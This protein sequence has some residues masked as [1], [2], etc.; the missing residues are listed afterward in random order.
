M[1]LIRKAS[2]L[3]QAIDGFY[4]SLIR[5]NVEEYKVKGGR[6]IMKEVFPIVP[7]GSGSVWMLVG[8]TGLM[9]GI[10]AL[11]AYMTYSASH[12]EFEIA[13]SGLRINGVYGRRI[14]LSQLDLDRADLVD[15]GIRKDLVPRWKTNGAGLPGYLTGWFRLK[16]KEKALVF[17][18]DRRQVVYLPTRR[19]Y[20][21][22]MSPRRPAEFLAA[23]RRAG[24]S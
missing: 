5:P 18:T 16:N 13:S 11:F 15:L 14:D 6:V 10:V 4:L 8:L 7:A 17:V 12:A 22:L 2:R 21:L 1:M 24:D 23:L 20:S 9:V 3:L 19:G